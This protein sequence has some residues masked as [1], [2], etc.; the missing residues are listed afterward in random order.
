MI[1]RLQKEQIDSAVNIHTTQMSTPLPTRGNDV[2]WKQIPEINV[3]FSF[4]F[5]I[6]IQSPQSKLRKGPSL[7]AAESHPI[8]SFNEFQE[9]FQKFVEEGFY[10][11]DKVCDIL[12]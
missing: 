4:V 9:L 10:T 8:I 12:L 1:H 7:G 3:Y 6:C 5:V 2:I 11:F